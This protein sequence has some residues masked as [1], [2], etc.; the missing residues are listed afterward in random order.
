MGIFT[1][2]WKSSD[3]LT[4]GNAIRKMKYGPKKKEII[5]E[6][7]ETGRRDIIFDALCGC[8]SDQEFLMSIYTKYNDKIIRGTAL[9]FI[10][11]SDFLR[12][13]IV[14]EHSPYYEAVMSLSHHNGQKKFAIDILTREIEIG[15][16]HERSS[17]WYYVCEIIQKDIT[18]EDKKTISN[19]I[20]VS[21]DRYVVEQTIKM[22][23]GLKDIDILKDLAGEGIISPWTPYN[24]RVTQ[25][26]AE[27]YVMRCARDALI[28][29]GI[30]DE[31]WSAPRKRS[32]CKKYI[33]NV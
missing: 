25:W 2:K 1:P 19:A 29:M 13:S 28:S 33:I 15:I 10:S 4:A 18:D 27:E 22:F 9:C 32:E 14:E 3:R 5:I 24:G 16:P 20:L 30:A 17:F 6:I 8:V 26:I 7:I 12:K 31:K 21:N 11:D 23:K